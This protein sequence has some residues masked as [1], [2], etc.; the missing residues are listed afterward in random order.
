MQLIVNI[1][2]DN[3]DMEMAR[4]CLKGKSDDEI[5][6]VALQDFCAL[7]HLQSLIGRKDNP[8]K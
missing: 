3:D 1:N 8:F 4:A 6:Q 2:I 5:V 7:I